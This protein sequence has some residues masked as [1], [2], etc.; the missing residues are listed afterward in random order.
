MAWQQCS[1]SCGK[2]KRVRDRKCDSPPPPTDG[3][4]PCFGNNIESETC[5]GETLCKDGTMIHE[6]RVTIGFDARLSCDAEWYLV[7]H[8]D[9][10]V[11]WYK[12]Q[13]VVE[14]T[15][16]IQNI[17]LGDLQI[18]KVNQQNEGVYAC[19][20]TKDQQSYYNNVVLLKVKTTMSLMEVAQTQPQRLVVPIVLPLLIFVLAV[21]TLR[22]EYQRMKNPSTK[23]SKKKSKKKKK[24]KK[25]KKEEES[26]CDD[27]DDGGGF[28]GPP[29]PPPPPGPGGMSGP[30]GIPPPSRPM[31]PPMGGLPPGPPSAGGGPPGDGGFVRPPM[32]ANL[33]Q[34]IKKH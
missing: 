6:L 23:R 29:P 16:S 11:E 32:S 3:G 28:G 14:L 17:G 4:E 20:I 8:P 9:A 10:T 2:G 25:S 18:T 12:D 19:A 30:P 26:S 24:A 22:R 15:G 31:M 33:L 21:V 1:A 34:G 27:D 13:N 5:A 7:H